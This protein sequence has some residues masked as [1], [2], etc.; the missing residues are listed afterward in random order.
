MINKHKLAAIYS[1][2]FNATIKNPLVCFSY[3]CDTLGVQEKEAT[4]VIKNYLF[5]NSTNVFTNLTGFKLLHIY[6]VEKKSTMNMFTDR[7]VANTENGKL[8][9]PQEKVAEIVDQSLKGEN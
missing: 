1:D 6:A 4:R 2:F 9:L 5:G 7:F 3:A 8:V